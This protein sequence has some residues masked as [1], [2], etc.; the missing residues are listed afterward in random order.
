MIC[1]A[2]PDPVTKDFLDVMGEV[3]TPVTVI[4]TTVDGEAH[5]TTVSAFMSLSLH[6]PMVVVSLDRSSDLLAK[7]RRSHRFG[8]NVL[9]LS[10]DRLAI[11]FAGKGGDK[12]AG[13]AWSTSDGL[14]RLADA[15]GW[16]TCRADSFVDGGDHVL[17]PSHVETA[18]AV[19]AAPLAYHRRAYGTHS[20]FAGT[21]Q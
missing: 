12:F 6:P 3:C 7:V 4:T 13:V 20:N 10:Q 5:G 17:I 18:A 19:P 15:I 8:V 9:G 16:L 11:Q 14:P 1:T 2:H 21:A